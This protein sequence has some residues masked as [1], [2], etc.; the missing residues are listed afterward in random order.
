MAP[1]R[2]VRRALGFVFATFACGPQG[3]G[4]G[5]GG[6]GSTDAS[7]SAEDTTAASVSSTTAATTS[8]A[9]SGGSSDEG[10]S[11]GDGS[12]SSETAASSSSSSDTTAA[13][14]GSDES[15]GAIDCAARTDPAACFHVGCVYGVDGSGCHAP[16]DQAQ[17]AGHG[18]VQS[19]FDAYCDWD[20]VRLTCSANVTG[21]CAE[22]VDPLTCLYSQCILVEEVCYEP[23]SAP[24]AQLSGSIECV[25]NLC[26]WDDLALQC[27]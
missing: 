21:D 22:I 4:D 2:R 25:M 12:G 15:G 10:S 7:G 27:S 20:P 18:D 24:C 6:G 5:T 1:T 16:Y 26:S 8:D 11:D 23:G 19:C 17:C 13:G 14:S 9:D 3:A